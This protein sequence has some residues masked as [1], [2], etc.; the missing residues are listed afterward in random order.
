MGYLLYR[1]I[2]DR[3]PADWTHAER[4][5][6]LMIADDANDDTR[7]SWIKMPELM[8]RTGIKTESGIRQALTRLGHRGYEFRVPITKDGMPVVG[9]DGRKVF[10]AKTHSLDYLVPAMPAQ[11]PLVSGTY[12]HQRPLVSGAYEGRSDQAPKPKAAHFR[13]KGRSFQ[14]PLSSEPLLNKTGP[15]AG[16][17]SHAS[18]DADKIAIV[19][20]AVTWTYGSDDCETISD[21]DARDIWARFISDR[22]DVA[23]PFNFLTRI[24]E[25]FPHVEGILA[26]T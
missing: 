9:K 7:R 6:A 21:D 3:A 10:A 20:E 17:R 12:D 11:R 2:R 15:S 26:N 16:P 13:D 19:R 18:A 4:L 8:A 25:D 23:K 14:A 24:F 22:T 1:E 5:V